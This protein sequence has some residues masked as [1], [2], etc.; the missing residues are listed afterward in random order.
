MLF[1]SGTLDDGFT[2]FHFLCLPN[3]CFELMVSGGTADS[4]ISFEFFDEIGGHF[5]GLTA[6][7]NVR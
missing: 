1:A 5:Q 4:E 2:A 7:F 6:P 3:G